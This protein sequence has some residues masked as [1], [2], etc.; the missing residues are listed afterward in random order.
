M[1]SN[2]KSI[3]TEKCLNNINKISTLLNYKK[4][5]LNNKIFY[6]NDTDTFM[7][8][9]HL[10]FLVKNI[11]KCD[12]VAYCSF[13]SDFEVYMNYKN[14]LK[15]NLK[16]I[17]TENINNNNTNDS[18]PHNN[19][20]LTKDFISYILYTQGTI[21]GLY[22]NELLHMNNNIFYLAKKE[23]FNTENV[24]MEHGCMY[25]SQW[26][27]Y[28]SNIVFVGENTNKPHFL[29][30]YKLKNNTLHKLP[31]YSPE[32][33]HLEIFIK[34]KKYLRVTSNIVMFH[35][36][37][38]S[39]NNRRNFSDSFKSLSLFEILSTNKIFNTLEKYATKGHPKFT[40]QFIDKFLIKT[41]SYLTF[42]QA[43]SCAGIEKTV[44]KFI[45]KHITNKYAYMHNDVIK[46]FNSN[47][48]YNTNTISTSNT[49]ISTKNAIMKN[50]LNNRKYYYNS[51]KIHKE[52]FNILSEYHA[53]I[54]HDM[55]DGD[56]IRSKEFVKRICSRWVVSLLLDTNKRNNKIFSIAT[57]P[58]I[59]GVEVAIKDETMW[60]ILG[61]TV[62]IKNKGSNNNNTINN[63][64]EKYYNKGRE[65]S[66]NI[67]NSSSYTNNTNNSNNNSFLDEIVECYSLSISN[68]TVINANYNS[69]IDHSI[70]I[71]YKHNHIA[72]VL[73][74]YYNSNVFICSSVWEGIQKGKSFSSNYISALGYMIL[75]DEVID[76]NMR[77]FTEDSLVG[78]IVNKVIKS[79][80]AR[81]NS[82]NEIE[83]KNI[84]TKPIFTTSDREE[85][86]FYKGIS[87]FINSSD[88]LENINDS[89]FNNSLFNESSRNILNAARY[90]TLLFDFVYYYSKGNTIK[91]MDVITTVINDSTSNI[92]LISLYINIARSIISIHVEDMLEDIRYK[93]HSITL[94]NFMFNTIRDIR[95]KVLHTKD[96]K[97]MRYNTEKYFNGTEIKDIYYHSYNDSVIY[98]TLLGMLAGD[99]VIVKKDSE[100]IDSNRITLIIKTLLAI[101]SY[102]HNSNTD[103]VVFNNIDMYKLLLRN[104]LREKSEK[105][106]NTEEYSKSSRMNKRYIQREIVQMVEKEKVSDIK[107]KD[108]ID[109]VLRD[110]I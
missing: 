41:T 38:I 9:I 55:G 60:F 107:D 37:L 97:Y 52:I 30:V 100:N 108:I 73:Y 88:D 22:N 28:K 102:N 36:E 84:I 78:V 72:L 45:S 34:D 44:D 27:Y 33:I 57:T 43:L 63:I 86:L 1:H 20:Y 29:F 21:I 58:T 65:F 32:P 106:H 79:I 31:I 109:K 71:K 82:K 70:L 76:S 19:I 39:D 3:T 40:V 61:M 101:F 23:L 53:K 4:V 24:C 80:D 62:D 99:K 54:S 11:V 46:Y 105:Y 7:D 8:K 59:N 15:T 91:V 92:N 75:S 110:I 56:S 6:Y 89:S 87:H 16:S 104:I 66:K 18:N 83:Y 10:P 14:K 42:E 68:N 50:I 35:C 81:Y 12:N 13:D 103:D 67:K 48:F 77:Y 25:L 85:V 96:I 98:H 17:P 94:N 26:V 95:A 74:Y 51:S 47:N 64:C 2:N 5:T 93:K 69:N 90:M 49:F